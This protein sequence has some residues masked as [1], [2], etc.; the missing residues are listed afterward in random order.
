M[1]SMLIRAPSPHIVSVRSV[2]SMIVIAPYH[3]AVFCD[4][5]RF[6]LAS[7]ECLLS[8]L[9]TLTLCV[10]PLLPPVLR[11]EI[12]AAR[13]SGIFPCIAVL[14]NAIYQVSVGTGSA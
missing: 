6:A 7:C 14:C 2:A 5:L 13:I 8:L 11:P 3:Y 4:D 9:P 12:S 10:S 1:V